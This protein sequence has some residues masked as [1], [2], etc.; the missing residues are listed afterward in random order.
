[1]PT[2]LNPNTWCI[3]RKDTNN[4]K[5]EDDIEILQLK[6]V[7]VKD[8]EIF[9]VNLAGA[10]K[11]VF[12]IQK[13]G[14]SFVNLSDEVED[15]RSRAH[16]GELVSDTSAAYIGYLKSKLGAKEVTMIFMNNIH[17]RRESGKTFFF[18]YAGEKCLGTVA[19]DED[20]RF[21]RFD[22]RLIK[23]DSPEDEDRYMY[24]PG[25]STS[26][27]PSKGVAQAYND[28][29][30]KRSNKYYSAPVWVEI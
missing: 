25:R 18:K 20:G 28:A 17:G 30:D 21:E 15:R 23:E 5:Y 3:V 19:E 8:G 16:A 9:R 24:Y 14:D 12:A 11:K 6:D 2:V 10:G 22:L 26:P 7:N 13:R 4:R 27:I 29:Q 1:M